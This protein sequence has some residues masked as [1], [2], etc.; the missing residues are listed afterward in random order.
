MNMDILVP[1]VTLSGIAVAVGCVLNGFARNNSDKFDERQL[2]ERGRGANLA[3]AVA[4]VYMMGLYAGLLLDWLPGEY[5]TVFAV[6]GL[7]VML[8]VDDFWCIFHDAYLMPGQDVWHVALSWGLVGG[9]W[10][11]TAWTSGK[12]L[13]TEYAWINGGLA[14]YNL[15][16]SGM[17]LLR[18]YILHIRDCREERESDRKER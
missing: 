3:M 9:L 8:M 16:R 14:L 18:A 15:S 7:V 1:V 2:I 13:G 5:A 11:A 12:R 17:L 4:M 6:Y 10:L